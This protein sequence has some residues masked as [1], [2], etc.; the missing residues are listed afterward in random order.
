MQELDRSRYGKTIKEVEYSLGF[1][2]LK[3]VVAITF[4]PSPMLHLDS[5]LKYAD[6]PWIEDK[7]V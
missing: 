2:G 7:K 1:I 5:K 4:N 6:E 3:I